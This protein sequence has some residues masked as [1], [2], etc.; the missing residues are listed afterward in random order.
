MES[1]VKGSTASS[2]PSDYGFDD[3]HERFLNMVEALAVRDGVNA[4]LVVDTETN[5]KDCRDGRGYVV[6][7]SMA[8]SL[9]GGT[10]FAHYF[11]VKHPDDP[12]NIMDMHLDRLKLILSTWRGW[13]VF[14]NAKFDL[15]ALQ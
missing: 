9:G 7:L 6:G 15:V 12:F 11:P 13:L 2:S 4:V 5:A 10:N 1:Q 14:H 3:D 8:L